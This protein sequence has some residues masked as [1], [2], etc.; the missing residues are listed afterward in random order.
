MNQHP[1][2]IYSKSDKSHKALAQNGLTP[3]NELQ[4]HSNT[5]WAYAF[6]VLAGYLLFK[7]ENKKLL[8][9]P[10]DYDSFE[11]RYLD[12]TSD[13]KN[14]PDSDI[15]IE[16]VRKEFNHYYYET[17]PDK[18]AFYNY[19]EK[20]V[21]YFDLMLAHRLAKN[22]YLSES[23]YQQFY[24]E[25]STG[26][27]I[28]NFPKTKSGQWLLKYLK[29]RYSTRTLAH[30][31]MEFNAPEYWDL[32]Y[33]GIAS[34]IHDL[35]HYLQMLSR[36]DMVHARSIDWNKGTI[37][38]LI[39]KLERVTKEIADRTFKKEKAELLEKQS[40]S[41]IFLQLE[42][43]WKWVKIKDSYNRKRDEIEAKLM[44]HC[45][46]PEWE[47]SFLI[48]LRDKKSEPWVTATIK[49]IAN[50]MYII[51]QVKGRGN[52]RP[53]ETFN[54]QIYKLFLMPEII[55]QK[56]NDGNDWTINNFSDNQIKQIEKKK[57]YFTDPKELPN[58]YPVR[59]LIEAVKTQTKEYGQITIDENGNIFCHIDSIQGFVKSHFSRYDRNK[60]KTVYD[61]WVDYLEDQHIDFDYSTPNEEAADWFIDEYMDTKEGQLIYKALDKELEKEDQ[62]FEDKNDYVNNLTWAFHYGDD[63]GNDLYSAIDNSLRDSYANSL[64]SQ[65]EKYLQDY[66]ER[67]NVELPHYIQLE[68]YNSNNIE[69]DIENTCY[70]CDIQIYAKSTVIDALS[71]WDYDDITPDA[72]EEEISNAI[73][74]TKTFYWKTVNLDDYSSEYAPENF[75]EQYL[76]DLIDKAKKILRV[77]K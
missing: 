31:W 13:F 27:Q 64:L 36:P 57:P 12:I 9:N 54:N 16:Q 6:M 22:I 32:I 7:K 33:R 52:K 19:Q 55:L 73:E 74:N 67:L 23:R 18:D 53:P 26:K 72:F 37:A 14:A 63:L 56:A 48:S 8:S 47:N 71:K 65:L 20:S 39:N 24:T 15:F 69:V 76:P 62:G 59:K 77:K 2:S 46:T 58:Y 3:A 17:V 51:G 49:E 1:L 30:E 70:Q 45:A 40:P 44:G 25:D 50:G 38:N 11:K 41:E 42:D 66:F 60:Q 75:Q 43:G 61:W 21:P 68:F 5:L 28:P 34:D 35:N 29:R 10:I 4:S